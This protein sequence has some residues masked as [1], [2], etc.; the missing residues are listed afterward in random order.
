MLKTIQPAVAFLFLFVAIDAA[1]AQ[2]KNLL[3]NPNAEQGLQYWTAFG[4]ATV[5]DCLVGSTCFVLGNDDYVLQDV[6]VAK[7]SVGLFA[8]LIA[9]AST[10]GLNL[11]GSVAGRPGLYGYMMDPGNSNSGYVYEYLQGPNMGGLPQASGEW[12]KLWG[13]YRI[14]EKTGRIRLFLFPGC[15][16]G[17]T[18]DNCV[19]RFRDTGVYLFSTEEEARRF[20][21]EF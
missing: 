20:V 7:D 16:K 3:Q 8:V 19:S 18:P 5:A 14:P 12:A 2:S 9:R 10:E 6:H 21:S 15:K 11:D 1:S 17:K 13:I 4:K